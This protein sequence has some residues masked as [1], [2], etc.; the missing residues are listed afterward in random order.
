MT[1]DI[2]T[3]LFLNK[4]LI[5]IIDLIAIFLAF[6]VFSDNP[7]EKVNRIY[8]WMTILM[9]AWVNFA[10]IPRVISQQ[11]YDFGLISLRVAWFVTPLFFIFL[12]LL[13]LTLSEK[14]YRFLTWS[15]IIIG[16]ILSLITGFSNSVI[17]GFQA[18]NKVTTI[19]YGN[20]KIPF[21]IG[22]SLI[23]IAILIPLFSKK[24]IFRDRKMQL[25]SFGLFTFLLLNVIF[26]ITLPMFF[27]ISR[28]YFL[29]DYSTLILLS[30]IAYAITTHKL[31]NTKV[32]VAEMISFFIWIGI[33]VQLLTSNTFNARLLSGGLLIFAIL[34]G[35]FLIRSVKKEVRQREEIEKLAE[36]LE[37]AYE[38]E[39]KAKEQIE[40]MAEDVR[41][42]YEVEKRANEELEQLDKVKNQFLMSVQH[43]LKTPLTSIM[44]YS[45]LILKGQFGKINK[46][47]AEVVKRF[48]VLAQDNIRKVKNF[49]DASQFQLGKNIVTLTPGV[50]LAP[51]LYEIANE[52]KFKTETEGLYIKLEKPNL[53]PIISADTEKLKSA[54]YN[55]I[56]NAIKYTKKG[57][58]TIKIHPV[59]SSGAGVLPSAKQFDRIKDQKS[60]IKNNKDSVV[61]EIKDTGIGMTQEQIND[62]FS[63]MFERSKE[64]KKT[65]IMGSGVGLYMAN[66]IIK[67]HNGSIRVESEGEGKGSTFYVE[68][69]MAEDNAK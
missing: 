67:M 21:L 68:L 39:K 40:K 44:W 15:V 53:T 22:I 33:A 63:K 14:K 24:N 47:V 54:L 17:S 1:S 19:I 9:M 30:F 45:D 20:F 32:I 6:I 27:G 35:T 49:L 51:V 61:I 13:S 41:R 56:D 48:Q 46:K 29:G 8:L 11:Y 7:K 57:G 34:F 25:F 43:D 16:T 66:Q 58:V 55:I 18:V 3:N 64:A 42:A 69:P 12:Y 31:F 5:A 62:L 37:V 60:N 52:F 59:K 10:Y 23:T 2:I 38:N 4:I 26:N 50:P 65:F 28:L 36:Q